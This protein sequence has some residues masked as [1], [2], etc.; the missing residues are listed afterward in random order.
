MKKLLATILLMMIAVLAL[1]QHTFAASIYLTPSSG[2]ISVGQ[3]FTVSVI[4]DTEGETVNTAESNITFSSNMIELIGVNQGSTFLLAAPA[5]PNMGSATAYFGGGLPNPGYNG[6]AGLLGTMTFRAKATGNASINITRGFVLLNDGS[7]TRVLTRTAGASFTITPAPVGTVLVASSTHPL[8]DSWSKYKDAEMHWTLPA[9]ATDV[10]YIFDQNPMTVPDDT[11]D[12]ATNNSVSYPNIK[13]GTWYFH[14]KAKSR[15]KN[16]FF[17]D[18]SHYKVLIDTVAPLPFTINLL[19]EPSTSDTSIT[20]TVEYS[21]NDDTSGV[22]RYD[23][24]MDGK[25]A[26]ELGG[27][28]FAFPKTEQG[29]HTIKVFAYDRA[30]NGTAAELP[31][32]ITIPGQQ[33]VTFDFMKK[34][35]Q[36]PLYG[37]I[38]LNL[39]ILLVVGVVVRQNKKQTQAVIALQSG[40]THT[41]KYDVKLENLKRQIDT[42]FDKADQMNELRINEL[43]VDV[44]KQIEFEIQKNVRE[45]RDEIQKQISVIKNPVRA[46]QVKQQVS[47]NIVNEMNSTKDSQDLE[48][49]RRLYDEFMNNKVS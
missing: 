25:L 32:N 46:W 39:I 37:L 18:V 40:I 43:R 48:V 2:R 29:P 28:P 24:Y 13:D 36:L 31:V 45:L 42:R 16:D 35:V 23:V 11:V 22:Y 10:S 17:G 15:G 7:G 30:G 33:P 26:K 12:V 6:K 14:I 41:M 27:S 4:A 34:F 1:P 19:S 21:A 3:E 38:L 5:S 8:Q 9:N 44:K 49:L 47:K 20:P